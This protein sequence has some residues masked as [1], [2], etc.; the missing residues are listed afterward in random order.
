M[1]ADELERLAKAADTGG[2]IEK[3]QLLDAFKLHRH[4]FIRL[5]RAAEMAAENASPIDQYENG[6][7]VYAEEIVEL[8]EALAPFKE[9]GNG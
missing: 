6:T 5:I 1:T 9:K 2:E 3:W 8:R 7:L 4:D